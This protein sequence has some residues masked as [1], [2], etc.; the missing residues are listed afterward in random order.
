M[1]DANIDQLL[2]QF[3]ASSNG[4]NFKSTKQHRENAANIRRIL[5][6][7]PVAK[8]FITSAYERQQSPSNK[9]CK[10]YSNKLAKEYKQRA[11][12]LKDFNIANGI[13]LNNHPSL[14]ENIETLTHLATILN[15]QSTHSNQL[16]L[17]AS[18][19]KERNR[20]AKLNFAAAYDELIE[21]ANKARNADILDEKLDYLELISMEDGITELGLETKL[22]FEDDI[23]TNFKLA[24]TSIPPTNRLDLETKRTIR[25]QKEYEKKYLKEKEKLKQTVQMYGPATGSY[26]LADLDQL[27]QELKH[28][29]ET[30]KAKTEYLKAFQDLPPDLELAEFRLSESKA[31][32]AALQEQFEEIRLK[33]NSERKTNDDDDNDEEVVESTS[34]SH[35]L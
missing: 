24:N 8:S 5:E 23:G 26:S 33:L 4:V 25:K 1:S 18:L 31:E 32:Y 13:D 34:S 10:N 35:E 28:L 29:N 6:S 27:S 11:K 20:K 2:L 22:S 12:K 15:T 21:I 16:I 7:D 19:L 3:V 9:R 30:L 17:G 14:K